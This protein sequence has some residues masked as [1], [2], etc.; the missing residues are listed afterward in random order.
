MNLF[1]HVAEPE[2]STLKE[3]SEAQP[4]TKVAQ[5]VLMIKVK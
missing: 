1:G 3:F 4:E 2:G 5:I